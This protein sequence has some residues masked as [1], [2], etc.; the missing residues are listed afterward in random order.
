MFEYL[1]NIFVNRDYDFEMDSLCGMIEFMAIKEEYRNKKIGFT[2]ANH[3]IY[4]NN[5]IRYLAKIGDNNHSAKKMFDNIGFEEFHLEEA[6]KKE[7]G[8]IGL[9]NY[10]YMI[11][12]KN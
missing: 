4:D 10:V 9:N 7:K 5:Y 8:D 12:S 6:S 3:I 1:N 11:F 2:L